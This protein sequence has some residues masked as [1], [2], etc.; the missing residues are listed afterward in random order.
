MLHNVSVLESTQKYLYEY[1]Q[2]NNFHHEA[3]LNKHFSIE[4][5]LIRDLKKLKN[6]NK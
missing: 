5:A 3:D 4:N 2:E 1:Y 6:I